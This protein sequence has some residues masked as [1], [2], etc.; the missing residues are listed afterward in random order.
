MDGCCVIGLQ[1][2]LVVYSNYSY[3]ITMA[4]HRQAGTSAVLWSEMHVQVS[5]VAQLFTMPYYARYAKIQKNTWS[6]IAYLGSF[7][8]ALH[9]AADYNYNHEYLTCNKRM[10]DSQLSLPHGIRN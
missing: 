4:A 2:A 6:G 7:K 8:V 3:G 1:K 5:A 9:T 10:T